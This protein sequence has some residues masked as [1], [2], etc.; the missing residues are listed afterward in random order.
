MLTHVV[1][2]RLTDPD[3]V[4]EALHRL[5]AMRGQIPSLV[6]IRAGGNVNSSDA[7]YDVVL[8][9]EHDD[10]KGLSEYV[11]HP[12]HQELLGWLRPRIASR[13]VVDSEDLG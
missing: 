5:R 7:A 4:P 11:E 6:D 1:A 3:D 2:F 9:T 10:A 13:V 8:I 12:V